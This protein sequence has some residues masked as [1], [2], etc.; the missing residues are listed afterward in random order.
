VVYDIGTP[1]HATH[2]LVMHDE[3]LRALDRDELVLHYQP[4]V[5]LHTGRVSCLEALVRWQHPERGL[6]PPSEFLPVAEQYSELIGPMTS[7][8]LRRALSDYTAWTAA[9]HDW[10][11]AVNLSHRNLASLEFADTV[12]QILRESGV[13]PGLLHLEVT[14]TSLAYDNELAA[15][16]VGALAAQ[17]ISISM[18]D[19]GVGFTSLTQ[20]RTVQVSEVKIDRAFFADLPGDDK[21]RAVVRSFIDLGHSLGCLVTAVGVESQDVADALVDAGCDQAQGYLWQRPCPWEEVERAFG[22]TD[23]TDSTSS[24]STTTTDIQPATVGRGSQGEPR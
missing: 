22:T 4:K 14:E 16:V 7:W 2:V 1:Q 10:A 21:D 9:G 6:L 18:D 8:V 15:Q 23:S 13:P 17:G 12:S 11:V 19:F 24:D 3:L 5:E 20:L